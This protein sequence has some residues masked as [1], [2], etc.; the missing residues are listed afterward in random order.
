MANSISSRLVGN[1]AADLARFEKTVQEQTLFTGAAAMA[2][3]LYAEVKLNAAPPRMGQVTGNL[4]RSIYRV[5][6]PEASSAERK[7]YKISWNKRTAPHGH[8][9]EFG[10]SRAAAKPFLRPAFDHV[11]RAINEGK[12]AMREKLT[13]QP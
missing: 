12:N 2:R 6:S 5:Y 1:L 7:T 9:L 10:T 13:Q 11:G 4:E 3:V 8:L